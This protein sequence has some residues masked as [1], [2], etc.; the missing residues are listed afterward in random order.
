M[1][2]P[3]SPLWA[4]LTG[5]DDRGPRDFGSL[6]AKTQP[7]RHYIC[8]PGLSPDA[9]ADGEA[10]VFGCGQEALRDALR[11]A[12]FAEPNA[13]F[14]GSEGAQD[15][16][17]VRTRLLG[18]PDDVWAQVYP[19]SPRGGQPSDEASSLAL[20]SQSR[21]GHGDLGANKARVKRIVGR[22]TQRFPVL[23]PLR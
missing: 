21:L 20:L 11:Q 8:P 5:P 14:L 10:P 12:V 3:L 16:Y 2:H 23:V 18:F 17:L 15:R 22:L 4:R 7:N 9:D 19:A 13:R 6:H 1:T